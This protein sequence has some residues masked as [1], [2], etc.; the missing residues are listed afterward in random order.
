MYVV[1]KELIDDDLLP[2]RRYHATGLPPLA[3]IV[4]PE[5]T[6]RDPLLIRATRHTG[7]IHIEQLGRSA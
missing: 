4:L 3:N 6:S 1:G 2:V 7:H 5:V